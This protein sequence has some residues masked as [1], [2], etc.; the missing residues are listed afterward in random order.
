[1]SPKNFSYYKRAKKGLK[2]LK[3]PSLIEIYGSGVVDRNYIFHYNAKVQRLWGSFSLC[4][5][6]GCYCMMLTNAEDRR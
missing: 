2:N 1:M 3:N 4:S 5:K 6:N